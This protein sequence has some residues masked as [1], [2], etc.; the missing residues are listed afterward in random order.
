MKN[1]RTQKRLFI[2]V[3]VA[4][5]VIVPSVAN[6][7]FLSSLLGN[8]GGA[9]QSLTGGNFNFGNIGQIISGISS[10]TSNPN[11][12]SLGSYSSAGAQNYG[13][14]NF[15]IGGGFTGGSTLGNGTTG[16]FS[17]TGGVLMV[18]RQEAAG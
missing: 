3:T 11:S 12:F 15:S 10:S 9:F 2:G 4:A 6:A 17:T 16:G 8:G 5:I 13:L 1:K 18:G 7:N 14:G